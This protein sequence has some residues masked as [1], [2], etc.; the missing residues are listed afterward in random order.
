MPEKKYE[1]EEQRKAARRNTHR[2]YQKRS[3]VQICLKLNTTTDADVI[4]RLDHVR[5]KL[6]YIKELIRK[7]MRS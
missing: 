3:Y 4:A 7:D 5:S 6:G 1:T 2:E